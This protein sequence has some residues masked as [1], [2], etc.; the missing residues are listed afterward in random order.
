MP[1]VNEVISILENLPGD[2][3]LYITP[4]GIFDDEDDNEIE[5]ESSMYCDD[6]DELIHVIDIPT[7]EEV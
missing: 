6:G 2:S 3:L 1:T 4:G 7:L 5:L